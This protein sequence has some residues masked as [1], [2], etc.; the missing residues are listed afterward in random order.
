MRWQGAGN[1]VA[2]LNYRNILLWSLWLLNYCLL[3]DEWRLDQVVIGLI[4]P[5]AAMGVSDL[6]IRRRLV[7]GL[8][9]II[10]IY[11]GYE[12]FRH[13]FLAQR[14]H[15]RDARFLNHALL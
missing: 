10:L 15:V 3:Y 4:C 9:M 1:R 12:L 11:N 6:Q 7:L 2:V 8:D 5:R 14:G 13:I